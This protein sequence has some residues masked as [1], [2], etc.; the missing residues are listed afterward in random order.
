MARFKV[1]E[2]AK[3]VNSPNCPSLH[4]RE[5]EIIGLPGDDP[6]WLDSYE[7]QVDGIG[8]SW[9]ACEEDLAKLLSDKDCY[10]PATD[11]LDDI[12]NKARQTPCTTEGV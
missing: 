6:D 2:R 11:S 1:G 3:I 9:F 4:G 10:H 5:C 12:L 8:E 7:I